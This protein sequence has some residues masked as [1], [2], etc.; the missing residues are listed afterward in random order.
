MDKDVG[1]ECEEM[2]RP[3]LAWASEGASFMPSPMNRTV[4]IVF[5]LLHLATL[6]EA[7]IA[8]FG[9]RRDVIYACFWMGEQRERMFA[10]GIDS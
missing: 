1:S 6:D 5:F 8:G 7:F 2:Q 9:E 3:I 4:G 10:F